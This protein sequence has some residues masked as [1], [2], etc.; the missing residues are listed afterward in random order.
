MTRPARLAA[1]RLDN[2]SCEAHNN[3]GCIYLSHGQ[4]DLAIKEFQQALA[5]NPNLQDARDNLQMAMSG[6]R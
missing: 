6:K 5:L 3:A 4:L 1:I 2:N